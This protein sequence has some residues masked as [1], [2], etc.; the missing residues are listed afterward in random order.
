MRCAFI[1]LFNNILKLIFLV[2]HI[3]NVLSIHCCIYVNWKTNILKFDFKTQRVIYHHFIHY[4][5]LLNSKYL[6]VN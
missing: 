4:Y 1:D 6:N 3:N 2:L 5:S